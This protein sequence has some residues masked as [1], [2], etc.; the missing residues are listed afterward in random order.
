MLDLGKKSIYLGLLA[1]VQ[2]LGIAL[3]CKGFFPYKVY[4]PGHATRAD[5]PSSVEL[6]NEPEFDR[7][8]F[9]LIDAL[10]K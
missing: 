5:Q 7:L 10:R 4:L 9:V 8:V 6:H 1:L 2:I 3:F